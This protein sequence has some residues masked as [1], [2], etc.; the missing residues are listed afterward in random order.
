LSLDN[1]GFAS[2][3]AP[4]GLA[5]TNAG[6][7]YFW[8]SDINGIGTPA[9]HKLDTST[10]TISDLG[11]SQGLSSTGSDYYIR[12][13]LSPDGSKVYTAS[14]FW[15]D[16]S[17]DQMYLYQ[18][19][20]SFP[21]LAVSADGGTV[22]V[23]GEWTDSVLDPEVGVAYIDWETWFPVA[24]NGQKLNQDGSILFQ[25]LADGI[26]MLAENTGR[27]LYRLQIPVTP[28]NVYDALV[29]AEG[30]DT[31]A[32]IT[33]AGVSFVDLSSLPLA[34]AYKRPLAVATHFRANSFDGQRGSSKPGPFHPSINAPKLRRRG[35]ET[36]P[37]HNRAALQ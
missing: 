5:V 28:A 22:D 35:D 20:S 33:A 14:A 3:V 32:V 4:T 6:M 7:V 26:D 24:A 30:T 12:V 27:L 8:T 19:F 29:V 18:V 23:A 11:Y 17:N 21:D 34:S 15:L 9:F 25:P 13:L 10:P 16:T 2:S 36:S 1:D 31:L 37:R